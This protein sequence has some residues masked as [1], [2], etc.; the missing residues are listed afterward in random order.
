M[1]S[2]IGKV[3]ISPA[4]ERAQMT[5]ASIRK[6]TSASRISS[7]PV[8]AERAVEAAS[9]ACRLARDASLPLAVVAAAGGLQQGGRPELAQPHLE[10]LERLDRVEV[11]G[12]Q[13]E[14]A[15]GSLLQ[16]PMLRHPE[17]VRS[18]ADRYE[19]LRAPS[20]CPRP[21]SPTPA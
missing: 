3:A 2:A 12:A 6:S 9:E 7:G 15:S 5:D 14:V 17:H 11:R 18:G 16:H 13:T 20:P 4:G 21:R 8:A 19:P 10:V 1:F